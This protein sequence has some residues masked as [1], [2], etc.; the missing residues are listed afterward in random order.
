MGCGGGFRS[1]TLCQ[2]LSDLSG[3]ELHLLPG[4]E[5][6][7]LLGLTAVC[8]KA[9]GINTLTESTGRNRCF[10][11]QQDK[12]IHRYHPIWNQNRLHANET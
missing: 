7:T 2:M 9:L 12:L 1:H 3:L 10:Q 4:Y 6:A 8:N 5:Q 11:P